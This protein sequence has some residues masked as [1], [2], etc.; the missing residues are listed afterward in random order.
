[1]SL[2]T[3][4]GVMYG[5]VCRLSIMRLVVGDRVVIQG[6]EKTP[7]YNGQVAEALRF[8][9]GTGRWDV[10]CLGGTELSI[11]ATNLRREE[12][13]AERERMQAEIDKGTA[14]EAASV[15]PDA[16][17]LGQ[18]HA[19]AGNNSTPRDVPASAGPSESDSSAQGHCTAEAAARAGQDG[20]G[21]ER[22]GTKLSSSEC[23]LQ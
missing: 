11:R 13:D 16:A 4:H 19:R 7:Q 6:L 14:P 22:S 8:F 20:P 15:S 3:E 2:Y 9:T 1:M 10:R 21:S 17:G 18:R 5:R 23:A 12:S